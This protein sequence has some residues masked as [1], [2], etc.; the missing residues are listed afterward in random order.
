MAEPVKGVM[1][2]IVDMAEREGGRLQV[3]DLGESQARANRHHTRVS[4]RR[5]L[6]GDECFEPAPGDEEE[7]VEAAV[8][9]DKLTLDHVAEAFRCLRTAFGVF[10][11]MDLL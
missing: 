1:E 11:D 10:S 4:N 8:P 5:R 3:V 7:D 6:V 2:E 9:G